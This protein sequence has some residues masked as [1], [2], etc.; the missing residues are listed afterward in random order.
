MWKRLFKWFF[1]LIVGLPAALI[2]SL[3]LWFT[4]AP[5]DIDTLRPQVSETL[6]DILGQPVQIGALRMRSGKNL[7]NLQIHGLTVLDRPQGQPILR[8][9][10]AAIRLAGASLWRADNHLIPLELYVLNANLALDRQPDGAWLF[11]GRSFAA[12]QQQLTQGVEAH[13]QQK[14][15]LKPQEGVIG[16]LQERALALVGSLWLAGIRLTETQVRLSHAPSQKSVALGRLNIQSGLLSQPTPQ[17]TPRIQMSGDFI[18]AWE[19]GKRLPWN[20]HASRKPEDTQRW[21]V[22]AQWDKLY[23]PQWA[24]L[25]AE[26]QAAQLRALAFPIRGG[27]SLEVGGEAPWH[28]NWQAFIGKGKWHNGGL[29]RWPT[30]I[31]YINAQGEAS[32]ERKVGQGWQLDITQFDLKSPLIWAKGKVLLSRMGLADS[33]HIDLTAKAGGT[34][35]KSARYFYPPKEMHPDLLEWLDGSLKKGLITKAN[36][37]IKGQAASIPFGPTSHHAKG[38]FRIEAELK[39]LDL[40]Y[41]PQLPLVK[42]GSGTII[43]EKERMEATV[44]AGELDKSRGIR[45]TVTIPQILGDDQT[46]YVDL[47]AE[48]S[49]LNSIWHKVIQHPQLKW[50]DH[51]GLEGAN[52]TGQG[53]FGLKMK[54]PLNH[55]KDL[56][57]RS[58]LDFKQ[59]RG[60][61]PFLAKPLLEGRGRLVIDDDVLDLHLHEAVHDEIP[62]SGRLKAID[63]SRPAEA[64][65]DAL[66]NA[67]LSG[68]KLKGFAQK[69]GQE[70][71]AFHGWAKLE[72]RLKRPTGER[73][74]QLRGSMDLGGLAFE[75]Y[76]GLSKQADGYGSVVADGRLETQKGYMELRYIHLDLG[77]FSAMGQGEWS[78]EREKGRL[79][80]DD[81]R[82]GRNR[83]WVAVDKR[84][85]G[86]QGDQLRV[87]GHFTVLDLDHWLSQEEAGNAASWQESFSPYIEEEMLKEIRENPAHVTLHADRVLL[88]NNIEA[89]AMA[90]DGQI[91]DRSLKISSC[92]F[93]VDGR[94]VVLQGELNWAEK[95][96]E[97]PYEGFL[98]LQS[99]DVGKFLTGVNLTDAFSAGEGRVHLDLN[100]TMRR[101]QSLYK[102]LSGSG[103]VAIKEGRVERFK[104][105]S[106]LLGLF[107]LQELPSLLAGDRPDLAGE[108]FYYRTLEGN[109]SLDE[110][111]FHTA[112][113]SLT[114]PSMKLVVSGE[115]G[116]ESGELEMLAGVRPLQSLDAVVTALPILGTILSG[117]RKTLLETQ[118][119]VGGTFEQ[120][121]VLLKPISTVAPGIVR[122][123]L[124]ATGRSLSGEGD[125]EGSSSAP[126]KE[127][128]N[129]SATPASVVPRD[130][131]SE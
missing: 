4:I 74:L 108:G 77:N 62:F 3:L 124:Q 111:Q 42:K 126:E 64:D 25:L 48:E 50:G 44:H 127:D 8:A 54:V 93:F 98:D 73:G 58:Q 47:Q 26:E 11:A 125:K 1:I 51:V 29:F 57:F 52:F 55:T 2:I 41:Y 65:L 107:S 39:G 101:D 128:K 91:D 5:P 76:H 120:P 87:D 112:G 103:S 122:D 6:S 19:E 23:P 116:L 36:V 90:F 16:K 70:P 21:Q 119:N 22:A 13:K 38:I 35:T 118:F 82:L 46:L 78:S 94:K 121:E 85:T 49:N 113:I 67:R 69:L 89:S 80:L 45:G 31:T 105:L 34:N 24:F 83:G 18:P 59:A 60:T 110:G 97:G 117:G 75:N 86:P 40:Q 30:P 53:L 32:G 17:D 68:E 63:Y 88:A 56:T 100:G 95:L 131:E 123:I 72:A 104:L 92:D 66:I 79:V 43:F 99:D 15:Q 109:F 102:A 14:L 130:A 9:D 61:F 28:A 71:P 106:A 81:L 129:R 114:G 10:V 96:G 37:R 84:H 7:L 20:V 33:P 12:W 115:A 27:F